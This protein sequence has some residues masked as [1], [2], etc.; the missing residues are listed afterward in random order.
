MAKRELTDCFDIL[1]S[2]GADVRLNEPLKWHTT[3]RVG[4]PA[5]VFVQPYSVESLAEIV[6]FLKSEAIEFRIIGG[7]SNIICPARFE[8]VVVS[9]KNLNLMKSEGER[10]FVQAGTSVNT[11]IWHCLSE[12]L[13]G[14]EFLTGLPGSVGGAILMNAGAFGGELGNRV[15]RVTYLDESNRAREIDGK[16]AGFSYRSS[17]FRS[18]NKIILGAEFALRRG[19]KLEISRRMSE[20]LAKRLEKQP[21]QYPSAGSVFMRPRPDFYVGSFIEKLGLKGFR[22]GDAEVS[23]KHAGFIVNKGDASQEDVLSLIEVIKQKVRE[24]AGVDLGTEIEIWKEV[25]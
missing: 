23:E 11:L 5:R 4:G 19:E 25:G 10:V 12:G 17:I 9:T 21:L 18:S 22:V 13:T 7:G 1:Y 24:A 15:A 6:S 2:L 3:I 16:A 20:I 8:G 14:L